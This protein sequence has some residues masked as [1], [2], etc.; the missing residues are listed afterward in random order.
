MRSFYAQRVHVTPYHSSISSSYIP[1]IS[2]HIVDSSTY[3]QLRS[4]SRNSRIS[5][6][7]QLAPINEKFEEE[8]FEN[9]ARMGYQG[10]NKMDTES[11]NYLKPPMKACKYDD[12]DY[13]TDNEEEFDQLK[14]KIE[15]ANII[16]KKNSEEKKIEDEGTLKIMK[17]AVSMK[18]KNWLRTNTAQA[19]I[20]SEEDSKSKK[21]MTNDEK[22]Q[23]EEELK[24]EDFKEDNESV[25]SFC[26]SI[27]D[28]APVRVFRKSSRNT[29]P[30]RSSESMYQF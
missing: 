13:S 1:N 12:G 7:R 15:Q 2:R 19:A 18:L 28:Q 26:Y 30:I 23:I 20:F 27:N 16:E 4:S 25:V 8:L 29:S 14:K 11:S 9:S 5:C 24:G 22:K 6:A 21:I 3:E 17:N 10:D